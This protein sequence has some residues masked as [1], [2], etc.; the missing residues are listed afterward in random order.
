MPTEEQ[1]AVELLG[2]VRHGRAATSM[3]ALPFLAPARHIV[4]DGRVL[5][6]LHRGHGYHR[7]CGG[8]VVA[9][10]ADNLGSARPG[11]SLWT[12]QVVGHCENADPGPA[13]LDRLG[14]GPALMDGEPFDPVHLV[15]EPRFAT[16]HT[17]DGGLERRFQHVL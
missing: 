8:G 3:R 14:P 15:I 11:E 5:L 17:L 16:V 10:G 9:Y 4:A 12:V 6:R 13:E 7:A 2:R 1:L